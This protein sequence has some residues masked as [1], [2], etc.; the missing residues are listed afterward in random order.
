MSWPRLHVLALLVL[1]A[2]IANAAKPFQSMDVFALQW[3][4]DPALSPDAQVVVYVRR[5]MDVMQDRRVSRLWLMNRDGSDHRALTSGESN[6]RSPTWSPTGDRLAFIE[7]TDQGAEIFVYWRKSGVVSR[8]SQLP[9][10][11]GALSWSPDSRN[12]AFSM[13]VAEPDVTLVSAPKAP[14]GAEWAPAP[15]VTTR[16]YHEADGRGRLKPGLPQYFI[17]ASDGGSAEQVTTLDCR[18]PRRPHWADAGRS[19]VFSANCVEDREKRYRNSEIYRYDLASGELTELTSQNGPDAGPQV[20][21]DGNTIAYWR[22]S[23]KV[24]TYQVNELVLM[25]LDGG[26]KRTLLSDLDRAI[27]DIRWS[28]SGKR[29]FFTYADQGVGKIASV[30]LSGRLRIV[31]DDFGGEA[32]G[33]PYGGGSYSVARNDQLVYTQ[34][35]AYRPAELAV[36]RPG[37]SGA[38]ITSLSA[39]WSTYRDLGEVREVNYTSSVDQRPIQGWLVMPP[40]Y[41]AAN[42][43]PLL[44]ENHGGPVS[45]YGPLFS[46]EFQLYAAAGYVVFYPNPRGSTSYGEEFGNLLYHNYPGD[47]YND[48]MDG[49]DYLIA[50]GIASEE[51]LFVT[52]GS[53]GGTMT[54]WMVSNNQRFKA[55]VVV[56]PVMNWI[57]KTLTADNHFWYANYRYPGQPWESIDTYMKFSPISRVGQIETPTLVMVGTD[58]LRTPVSEAKQLYHALRL[59]GVDT[60]LVELPG[61]SHFIANRPSQL[62]AKVEHVIHWLDRYRATD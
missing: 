39:S 32:I 4:S 40:N 41:D 54:A 53:A 59:R 9:Q 36:V 10:S 19:L 12:L 38:T 23:D 45:H 49:V 42:S 31:A 3:A 27:S 51:S 56:K 48:V 44:V 13:L 20:S 15:R 22:Y 34:A 33:R 57:S 14:P 30:T 5:S 29:V 24:Q 6:Q 2:G 18:L 8:I 16:L 7:T 62:I 60:A 47:D 28:P 55:A 61:A 21:P 46:P 37:G 26:N 17:V 52:G 50:Q 1:F 25:D 58:D 35:S 43:Y 11:P